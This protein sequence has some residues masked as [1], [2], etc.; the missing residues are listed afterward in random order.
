MSFL[1]RLQKATNK[2]FL[3]DGG[4]SDRAAEMED[5]HFSLTLAF[6]LFVTVGTLGTNNGHISN[7]FCGSA[8][9]LL[10]NFRVSAHD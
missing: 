9:L 10:S 4:T 1:K 5:K 6:T 2:R 7:Y 8:T 3:G